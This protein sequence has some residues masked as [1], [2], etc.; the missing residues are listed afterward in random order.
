MKEL[1]DRL[2]RWARENA[3]KTLGLRPGAS[4]AAIGKAEKAMKLV[5]PPDLR[6]SLLAHDGQDVE[7][8]DLFEWLP[9][10]APLQPLASIV[11][12]WK[13]EVDM[14]ADGDPDDGRTEGPLHAVLR[15]AKRIPIAGTRYWDGDNTYVDLHPS[16]SG[17]A[18]Q[19]ITFTSECDLSCLGTSLTDAVTHYL[20][21][22]ESGEWVYSK[23]KGHV[24]PKG[25]PADEHPNESYEFEQYLAKKAAAA[26]K[27]AK[28]T[29]AAK[30]PT[31]AAKAAKKPAT[32]K[33]ATKK[34]AAKKP[35]TKATKR[36]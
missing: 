30:A 36:R 35:A 4:A 31:P 7:R 22:L 26:K 23:A 34:P 12:R 6:A 2:E 13:D 32:K 5:F 16:S 14:A 20:D 1:W 29:P 3:G 11:E 27:T 33:P 25:E 8:D 9:G 21:A 17:T 24:M 19:I 18:G 10:V 28:A 15:H